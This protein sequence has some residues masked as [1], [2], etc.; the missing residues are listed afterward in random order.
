MSF[1]LDYFAFITL[2]L[3]FHFH[4]PK[5][6]KNQKSIQINLK[7]HSTVKK[8]KTKQNKNQKFVVDIEFKL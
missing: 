5:K 4:P 2:D 1:N 3:I 8:K 7:W 6:G